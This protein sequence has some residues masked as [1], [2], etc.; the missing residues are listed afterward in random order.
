MLLYH[1][2]AAQLTAANG[3]IVGGLLR[4][5]ARANRGLFVTFQKSWK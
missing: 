5:L 4:N 2:D 1:V 3:K